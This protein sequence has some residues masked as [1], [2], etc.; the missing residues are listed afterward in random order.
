MS[1]LPSWLTD[2]DT[3]RPKYPRLEFATLRAKSKLPPPPPCAFRDLKEEAESGFTRDLTLFS[4][5]AP[6]FND[7]PFSTFDKVT[8]VKVKSQ[9]PQ[10]ESEPAV[11]LSKVSSQF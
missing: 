5:V 7:I 8:F 11:V 2:K 6:L 9:P 1:E 4:I 3:P 10:K